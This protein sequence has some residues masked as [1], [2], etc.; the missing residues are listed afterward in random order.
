[1]ITRNNIIKERNHSLVPGVGDEFI[2]CI[3]E[4]TARISYKRFV[5]AERDPEYEPIEEQFITDVFQSEDINGTLC[6]PLFIG[7]K[8]FGFFGCRT[9]LSSTIQ[10]GHFYLYEME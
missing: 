6:E 4:D 10:E 8:K 1:M 7:G 2:F 3:T 5:D 9:K